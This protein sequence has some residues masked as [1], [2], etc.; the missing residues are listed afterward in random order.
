M[1]LFVVFGV[2]LVSHFAFFGSGFGLYLES[3]LV[4]LESLRVQIGIPPHR[5]LFRYQPMKWHMLKANRVPGC[6]SSGVASRSAFALP[7]AR[8]CCRLFLLDLLRMFE[9]PCHTRMLCCMSPSLKFCPALPP[10]WWLWV[11]NCA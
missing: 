11:F 6:S 8:S 9:R 5:I 2:N 1:F 7:A 3:K 10:Q 4:F